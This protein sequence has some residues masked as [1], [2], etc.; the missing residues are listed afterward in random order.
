[1][2]VAHWIAQ[3]GGR[4]PPPALC[5][6]VFS[7]GSGIPGF[8]DN[9][10]VSNSRFQVIETFETYRNW[11]CLFSLYFVAWCRILCQFKGVYQ[12]KCLSKE[13]PPAI[14]SKWLLF[15]ILFLQ[16]IRTLKYVIFLRFIYQ[17]LFYIDLVSIGTGKTGS[18]VL[19]FRTSRNFLEPGKWNHYCR[20][21]WCWA[22]AGRF[23][24]RF[25]VCV[26]QCAFGRWWLQRNLQK[27]KQNRTVTP[28]QLVHFLVSKSL[29][30]LLP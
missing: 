1:M 4:L 27:K 13:I 25:L 28:T 6:L 26:Q 24:T 10:S 11:I 2:C 23:L 30:V 14:C 9:F 8:P 22:A 15:L 19:R 29:F 16:P 7:T 18:R 20:Q 3:Q 12:E 21:N 5:R 17:F